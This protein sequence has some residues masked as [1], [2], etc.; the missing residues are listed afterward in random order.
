MFRH[1]KDVNV[2]DCGVK[3]C[4]PPPWHDEKYDFENGGYLT[5]RL[6]PACEE[7][8]AFHSAKYKQMWDDQFFKLKVEHLAAIYAY[9]TLQNTQFCFWYDDCEEYY[10]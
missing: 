5:S 7:N 6:K 10:L 3:A 8:D 1:G 9:V 4:C 2:C